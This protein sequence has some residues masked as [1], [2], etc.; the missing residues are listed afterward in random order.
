M[1]PDSD[2]APDPDPA[3]FVSGFAFYFLKVHLRQSSKIKSH[4]EVTEQ[5]LKIKLFCL[6]MEG[7]GSGFTVR[8]AF[9]APGG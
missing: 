6:T 4:K 5:Y 7:S 8:F 1:D 9:R 3:L 2:P